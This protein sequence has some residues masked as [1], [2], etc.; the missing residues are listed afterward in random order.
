M[1]KQDARTGEN[2]VGFAII[3]NL[4]KGCSFGHG[5]RALRP[6]RR[7]FVR[8]SVTGVAETFT[9]GGIVYFDRPPDESYGF[10]QIQGSKVYA[11][12]SFHQQL[13]RQSDGRLAP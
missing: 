11:F 10:Q 7:F 1:V 3:R 4:P 8:C 5:V 6:E 9:R 12:L 13:K 2:S